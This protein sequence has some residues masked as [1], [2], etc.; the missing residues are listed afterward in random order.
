MLMSRLLEKLYDWLSSAET[1]CPSDAIV[2]L[3][4]RQSR[5][6]FALELFEQGLAQTLLLS[7]WRFEVRKFSQLLWPAEINLLQV[8]V[9]T[10]PRLRY[11]FVSFERG[12]T[13]VERILRGR[14]GTLSEIRAL[15]DWLTKR[16]EIRSV[17]VVSSAPHLRR[18]RACCHA[19]LP[20]G[21]RIH[22]IATPN[23]GA[24]ARGSWWRNRSSRDVVLN[25]LPKL[26]VYRLL[27]MGNK[28]RQAANLMCV[29]N[30][31]LHS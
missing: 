24:L 19:L 5:K 30:R 22:F 27:L 10:E 20:P 18:V 17:L 6:V 15:A 16:P 23:D 1:V 31:Q 7:V 4:G 14:F 8:A 2:C 28:N 9:S 25:E 26:L 29:S 11:Y 12:R 13:Q 3:S 21:L